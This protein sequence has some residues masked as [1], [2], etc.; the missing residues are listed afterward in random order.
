MISLLRGT[1]PLKSKASVLLRTAA[2]P[3]AAELLIAVLRENSDNFHI[4]H[5]WASY[6]VLKCP[7]MTCSCVYTI[8]TKGENSSNKIGV[9]ACYSRDC[10]CS[11]TLGFHPQS[12]ALYNLITVI[13]EQTCEIQCN[14]LSESSI[15]QQDYRG[16]NAVIEDPKERRIH[17]H[18]QHL[19]D[20]YLIDLPTETHTST[21]PRP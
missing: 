16:S 6:W 8:L 7:T 20:F 2:G 21:N 12:H 11:S 4:L 15:Q 9:F 3:H 17:I 18:K 14:M 5:A 13:Q 1:S 19:H 10:I